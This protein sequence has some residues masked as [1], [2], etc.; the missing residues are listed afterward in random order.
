MERFT[1]REVVDMD[2]AL[3]GKR[4]I[5]SEFAFVT[6]VAVAIAL[7]SSMLPVRAYA[8]FVAVNCATFMV[9]A[10]RRPRGEAPTL[11]S[12]Y[13]LTAFALVLLFVPL[14]FPLAAVLQRRRK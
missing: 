8:A 1:V 9:L 11:V 14:F 5:V 6:V 3:H 12:V 2:V 4:F 10:A 7:I 13:V